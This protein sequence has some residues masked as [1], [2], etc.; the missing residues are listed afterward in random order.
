MHSCAGGIMDLHYKRLEDDLSVGEIPEVDLRFAFNRLSPTAQTVVAL[1]YRQNDPKMI[2]EIATQLSLRIGV[3]GQIKKMAIQTMRRG[4]S[5][6]RCHRRDRGLA[7]PADPSTS[8]FLEAYWEGIEGITVTMTSS[9]NP[10]TRLSVVALSAEDERHISLYRQ[11][12]ERRGMVAVPSPLVSLA[13]DGRRGT[14][15][16]CPECGNEIILLGRI[17]KGNSS[18]PTTRRA[19]CPDCGHYWWTRSREAFDGT[20]Q[21]EIR[22]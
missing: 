2:K 1:F 10:S 3:V 7:E 9:K 20:R 4:I 8:D 22:G 21:V 6:R 19:R 16:G 11:E 13:S 17:R 18:T 15:L 5:E 14:W 12:R